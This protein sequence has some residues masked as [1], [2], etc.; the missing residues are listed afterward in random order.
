MLL[1]VMG[2][3]VDIDIKRLGVILRKLSEKYITTLFNS[4]IL[5]VSSFNALRQA[6]HGPR[7]K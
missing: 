7:S 3:F 2:I 5:R 4:S 6:I 1:F